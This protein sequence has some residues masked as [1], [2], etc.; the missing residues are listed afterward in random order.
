MGIIYV[1]LLESSWNL[2]M[3]TVTI[4][5]AWGSLLYRGRSE[6]TVLQLWPY[7]GIQECTVFSL[8]L[9][10]APWSVPALGRRAY[11][12]ETQPWD[13]WPNEAV[14]EGRGAV[15]SHSRFL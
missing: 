9:G 13:D 2:G 6:F 7:T 15:P 1:K 11:G 4:G 3:P 10:S 5:A 12:G 14:G 8:S